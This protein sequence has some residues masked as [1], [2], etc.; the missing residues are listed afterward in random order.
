M[1]DPQ[2]SQRETGIAEWR[3]SME[4]ELCSQFLEQGYRTEDRLMFVDREP[5]G[6]PE[7]Q[8]YSLQSPFSAVTHSFS[9]SMEQ[10]RRLRRIGKYPY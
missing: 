7:L 5:W 9:G 10:S 6:N 8:I 2:L 1:L 3:W 4:S